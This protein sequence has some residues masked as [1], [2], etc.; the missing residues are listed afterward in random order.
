MP[1]KDFFSM[2]DRELS[3]LVSYIRSFPPVN[4][5]VP[6]IALGPV[7][8]M[9][10]ATG[11]FELSADVHP[12]KHEIAHAPLPPPALPDA[13]FGKHLAQTCTGCH[14]PALAGGKIIGGPPDWP[15]AANLTPTGLA[16][17]TFEDFR[18]A[19]TEAKSK[20]GRALLPPMSDMPKFAKNMTDVELQ[21]LWAFISTLP[22][23]ATP[24]K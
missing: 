13:T 4:K 11:Q 20:N 24:A 6:P 21:A 2:S 9:L 18:R 7:G 10:V 15:P 17:W 1:A 12:T 16:G 23:Q 14:G 19:L 22:P 3:D 5:E 8:K